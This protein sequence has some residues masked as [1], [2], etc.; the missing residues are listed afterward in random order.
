MC[1]NS[2]WWSS[3]VETIGAVTVLPLRRDLKKD[4]MLLI[5]TCD[6]FFNFFFLL[7]QKANRANAKMNEPNDTCVI[8]SSRKR[9]L[10]LF[11]FQWFV[12]DLEWQIDDLNLWQSDN[13][14]CFGVMKDLRP[15]TPQLWLASLGGED[16]RHYL[17]SI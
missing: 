3:L 1:T 12:N 6:F 17:P 5:D 16:H 15:I 8:R 13:R 4:C 11:N 9:L 2:N 14:I 7:R 10:L